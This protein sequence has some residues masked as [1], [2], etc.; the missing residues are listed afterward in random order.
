[1]KSRIRGISRRLALAAVWA[2]AVFS[3]IAPAVAE[4]TPDAVQLLR[5]VLADEYKV[6]DIRSMYVRLAVKHATSPEEIAKN[7]ARLQAQNPRVP[8]SEFTPERFPELRPE[9]SIGEVERAFDTKRLRLFDHY[10]NDIDLKIWDGK[11]QISYQKHEQFKF[12]DE[13]YAYV[14]NPKEFFGDHFF[15]NLPWLRLGTHSFWWNS[16]P[17]P[18]AAEKAMWCGEQPE[19]YKYIGERLY[20]DRQCYVLE[21]FKELRTQVFVDVKYH[22]LRGILQFYFPTDIALA[23]WAELAQ[24]ISGK[25]VGT[26]AEINAWLKS[27][28]VEEIARVNS[29]YLAARHRDLDRPFC[30]YFADDYREVAPGF[31]F[32]MKQG[33]VT[34]SSKNG[35]SFESGNN[36]FQVVEIKVN[37]P[38][39]DSLFTM[40]MKEGVKVVDTRGQD[41]S[42]PCPWPTYTYKKNRPK[43]EWQAILDA[44]QKKVDQA[45]KEQAEK[46]R[47]VGQPALEFA[48][49]QWL[50]SKPLKLAD[51]QGKVVV[52]GFWAV[53]CGP[54]RDDL[55]RMIAWHNNQS[56]SEIVFIGVHISGNTKEEI[57]KVVKQYDMKYPIYID[58]P[59]E[60]GVDAFGTMTGWYGVRGIPYAVVIDRDGKVAGHGRLEEVLK[61]VN[62]LVNRHK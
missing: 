13:Q 52:L 34:F 50:N 53:G 32:P 26:N 56:A 39:P 1:M 49:L 12:K 47:R 11:T 43:E 7:L 59:P 5:A 42:L 20:R 19:D 28:P 55:P 27:L 51:L 16:V 48:G 9:K 60:P 38:L 40:E 10:G 33:F 31:W 57:Q 8:P 3:T 37:Q 45:R 24:R 15:D 61:K 21:C 58:T 62:E 2:I 17:V 36:K 54:C 4:E 29:Q 18:T 14:D 46:D 23:K 25:K 22:R 35:L 41:R 44:H 6:H 30:D